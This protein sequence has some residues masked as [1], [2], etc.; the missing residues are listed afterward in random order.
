MTLFMF[1]FDAF[2]TLEEY[3]T[4]FL[5]L[6]QVLKLVC[7]KGF[8]DSRWSLEMTIAKGWGRRI[9]HTQNPPSSKWEVVIS[10][11]PLGGEKSLS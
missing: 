7:I 3:F 5:I 4:T 6:C 10:N 1:V 9:L 11:P 8:L 2:L